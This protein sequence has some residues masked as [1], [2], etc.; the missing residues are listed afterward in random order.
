[1]RKRARFLGGSLVALCLGFTAL[2]GVAWAAPG[3]RPGTLTMMTGDDLS[4]QFG[5][6][7]SEYLQLQLSPREKISAKPILFSKRPL[8]GALTMGEGEDTAFVCVLDESRG[9]GSGYDTL[10]IDANNNEDLSDDAKVMGKAQENQRGY[11]FPP[12]ELSVSYGEQILPYSVSGRTYRNQTSDLRFMPACYLAGELKIGEKT[13]PIALFDDTVN[14]LFN[15]LYETP[16]N[17]SRTGSVWARGDSLLID[18]DRDGSMKKHWN[19]MSEMFCLGK[20]LCL[21]NGCYELNVE[22]TGRRIGLAEATGDFGFF[23]SDQKGF[24]VDL[25]GPDGAIKLIDTG[26]RIPVPVGEYRF[27]LCRFEAKDNEDCLWHA[28]GRGQWAQ[29]AVRI[30]KDQETKVDFGFPL[31]AEVKASGSG[32]EYQFDLSITGAGG[33]TYSASTFEASD[34]REASNPRFEVRDAEG[35]IQAQGSFQYG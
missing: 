13:Y 6:I 21:D 27:A 1:M 9:T 18:L 28:T 14:G 31:T 4:E 19:G 11:E 32:S 2:S 24:C 10:Y 33:E 16:D 22:P 3:Q 34:G 12:V 7:P 35:L 5:Y 15:D 8:Y 20:Y 30:E 17:A 29:P 25:Y 26:K 23:V